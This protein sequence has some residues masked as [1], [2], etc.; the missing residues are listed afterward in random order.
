M[1][2]TIPDERIEIKKYEIA[3]QL[4]EK[5]LEYGK[6]PSTP[7]KFDV[8][9]HI[10]KICSSFSGNRT[11]QVFSKDCNEFELVYKSLDLITT[12]Y[13]NWSGWLGRRTQPYPWT[14]ALS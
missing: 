1:V 14:K 11:R 2:G 4:K 8:T 6:P 12:E 5:E 10:R 3:V 13:I 7:H 9:K